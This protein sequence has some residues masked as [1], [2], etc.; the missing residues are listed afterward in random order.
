MLLLLQDWPI[1]VLRSVLE[2]LIKET[3]EDLLQ[4]ELWCSATGAA[5]YWSMQQV[6]PINC[7]DY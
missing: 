3:P 4:K 6:E 7:S 5:E 2:D 1:D